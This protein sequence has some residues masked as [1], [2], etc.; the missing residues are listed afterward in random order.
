MS[1]F[2]ILIIT[3]LVSDWFFQIH[4][5]AINKKKNF[6]YLLYHCIQY[7]ILFIPALYLLGISQIWLIW[8]FITHLAIDNY[9]FVNTW[10][11]YIKRAKTPI[12][13]WHLVVQDQILHVIVLVPIIII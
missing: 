6:K 1:D 13:D 7:T 10:N 5:W 9:W 2:S 8:I 11:K 12:P 4:N 3:H